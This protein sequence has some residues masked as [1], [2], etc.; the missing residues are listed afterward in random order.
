MTYNTEINDLRRQVD[1]LDHE[2]IDKIVELSKLI[3]CYKH[4]NNQN[5]GVFKGI[6][7]PFKATR[8]HSLVGDPGSLPDCLEV[9]ATSLIDNEIM[10]IR[11]REYPIFGVQFHPESIL[12]EHG[13]QII[14]N[15]L[16][17]ETVP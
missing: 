10:G 5:T 11:H 14:R 3:N 7:S 1:K 13:K 12:T 4:K 15:F 16:D 17:M 2:I 8:Y 9:T 6:A